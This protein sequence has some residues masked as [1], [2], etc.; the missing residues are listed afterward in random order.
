[1]VPN[2]VHVFFCIITCPLFYIITSPLCC[3]I[4]SALSFVRSAA[5]HPGMLRICHATKL[6]MQVGG[7]ART[8]GRHE[9]VVH[10]QKSLC[11][12]QHLGAPVNKHGAYACMLC[13]WAPGGAQS[14]AQGSMQSAGF[15]KH[16]GAQANT[17]SIE[18]GHI[19][20]PHDICESHL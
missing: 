14:H 5:A 20:Y 6:S 4:T 8:M 15:C 18:C 11:V 2:M 19:S 16:V 9:G 13:F 17:A 1:M 3:I 10:Q 12:C 7:R